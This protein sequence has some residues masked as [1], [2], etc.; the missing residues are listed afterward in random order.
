MRDVLRIRP[1]L[2]RT[3][4]S[5]VA[6]RSEL[7]RT[8]ERG[9]SFESSTFFTK[10]VL[11]KERWRCPSSDHFIRMPSLDPPAPAPCLAAFIAHSE[12]SRTASVVVPLFKDC[13]PATFAKPSDPVMTAGQRSLW[14]IERFAISLTIKRK[15]C[16]SLCL[17][18]LPTLCAMYSVACLRRLV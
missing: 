7:R 10:R 16:K 12:N 2:W 4:V 3:C 8:M 11:D 9:S 15:A 13:V 1:L 18:F 17:T 6:A 5:N 14:P